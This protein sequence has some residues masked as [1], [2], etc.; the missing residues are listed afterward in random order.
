[1]NNQVS[2]Q[3]IEKN[4]LIQKLSNQCDRLK[5][6][7]ERRNVKIERINER[8]KFKK[9]SIS[10]SDDSTTTVSARY[11]AKNKRDIE[12]FE[13]GLERRN[14]R[15]S[16]FEKRLEAFTLR[17]ENY[18][19]AVTDWQ[20]KKIESNRIRADKRASAVKAVSVEGINE[21]IE[22]RKLYVSILEKR[23]TQADL[24]IN[25]KQKF[26]E[27]L[28]KEIED[29]K[30]KPKTKIKLIKVETEK[31]VDIKEEP[32]EEITTTE[33]LKEVQNE[34][35]ITK[36]TEEPTEEPIE[37]PTEVITTEEPTKTIETKKEVKSKQPVKSI[38]KSQSKVVNKK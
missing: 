18:R 11:E 38:I 28:K 1:M 37:E 6:K 17:V 15:L 25:D 30:N 2:P 29:L 14:S 22:K 31:T 13:K 27:K 5:F 32:I 34:V 7:T 23:N 36:P 24:L 21:Y 4:F 3:E 26:I 35:I 33:E 19:K 9:D 10:N 20:N 12:T 16:R 8:L